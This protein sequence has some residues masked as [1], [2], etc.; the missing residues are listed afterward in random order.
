MAKSLTYLEANLLVGSSIQ[1]V[2]I[3]RTHR[4]RVAAARAFHRHVDVLI[5]LRLPE[6]LVE[7]LAA[8]DLTTVHLDDDVARPKARRLRGAEGREARDDHSVGSRL[9]V[10]PEP[11]P[12]RAARHA[13]VGDELVPPGE[14]LLDGDGEV[15]VGRL[16]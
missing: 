6:G 8:R 2:A 4:D 14:E 5:H 16:A 9:G 1:T 11:G 3:H 13:S 7:V 12:G 10:E 15:D